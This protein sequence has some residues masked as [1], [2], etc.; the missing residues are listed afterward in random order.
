MA[1]A[2]LLPKIAAPKHALAAKMLDI[3]ISVKFLTLFNF[4]E[5]LKI[6]SMLLGA[7]LAVSVVLVQ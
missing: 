6:N 5:Y 1:L 2:M 4:A 3:F 7:V